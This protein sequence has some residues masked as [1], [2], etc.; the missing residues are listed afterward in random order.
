MPKFHTFFHM[1]LK[2]KR[3]FQII[4]ANFFLKKSHYAEKTVT[5]MLA[6]RFMFAEKQ[7]EAS[8]S[9]IRLSKVRGLLVSPQSLK[10]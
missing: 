3:S 4:L 10:A 5:A 1:P 9:K 2:H 7:R 8:V 6:K